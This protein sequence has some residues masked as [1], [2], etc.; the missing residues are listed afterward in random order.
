MPDIPSVP[1][2]ENENENN[3]VPEAVT[4]PPAVIPSSSPKEEPAA[5]PEE[6]VE[7][8]NTDSPE[9][10]SSGED[11]PKKSGIQIFIGF[12]AIF[13]IALIYPI[14]T[15]SIS[16]AISTLFGKNLLNYINTKSQNNDSPF[17][18]TTFT[19]RYLHI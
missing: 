7:K 2:P 4:P 12:I 13:I 11:T 5:A 10:E 14:L 6:K 19:L 17:S 8:T 3:T 9:K 15:G 18:L 16:E 1:N